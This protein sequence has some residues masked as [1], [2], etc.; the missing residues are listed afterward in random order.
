MIRAVHWRRRRPA[1]IVRQL[2]VAAL[3]SFHRRH[4]PGRRRR[5]ALSIHLQQMFSLGDQEA[6]V[7]GSLLQD[8]RLHS[9]S[10]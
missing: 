10:Q 6:D 3:P 7:L 9:P 8:R 4:T 1:S 5:D 2:A